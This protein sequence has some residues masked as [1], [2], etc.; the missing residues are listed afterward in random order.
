MNAIEA[1]KLAYAGSHDWY[2]G[3]IADVT[4]GMANNVPDGEAHPIGYVA[5]HILH[6]EDVMINSVL[7]GNP[8]IWERDGWDKRLGISSVA[9][10]QPTASAQAYRCDPLT[11][12]DYAQTVY[13]GTASYFEGLSADALDREVDLSAAGLGKMGLGTFLLTMLLGNNYAHTGEISA[14]KGIMGKKGY[15]F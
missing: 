3:T 6:C 8:S 7:Q 12:N 5:A 4:P 14:L 10:D 1:I 13:K 2:Q 15:P 9:L 11:L